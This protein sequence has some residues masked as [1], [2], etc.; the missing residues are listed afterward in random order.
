MLKNTVMQSREIKKA[1][2]TSQLSLLQDDELQKN[3]NKKKPFKNKESACLKFFLYQE[4]SKLKDLLIKKNEARIKNKIFSKIVAQKYFVLNFLIDATIYS[5][6]DYFILP[7]QISYVKRLTTLP[8][9]LTLQGNK[10]ARAFL[11]TYINDH[12]FVEESTY[13]TYKNIIIEELPSAKK[14]I[15]TETYTKFVSENKRLQEEYLVQFFKNKTKKD[16][17]DLDFTSLKDILC[18]LNINVFKKANTSN[19][20]LAIF[21]FFKNPEKY[22]TA[23]P[24]IYFDSTSN[25][26]QMIATTFHNKQAAIHSC[27]VGEEKY[28]INKIFLKDINIFF[29]KIKILSNDIISKSGYDKALLNKD[30]FCQDINHIHNLKNIF[31]INDLICLLEVLSQKEKHM[32]TSCFTYGVKRTYIFDSKTLAFDLIRLNFIIEFIMK[33]ESWLI[34]ILQERD[35]IKKRIMAEAYGMTQSGGMNAIENAINEYAIEHGHIS[36]NIPLIRLFANI[37]NKYFWAVFK[38]IYL[39]YMID[40]LTLNTHFKNLKRP[41]KYSDCYGEWHYIP[42][43]SKRLQCSIK[44]Y[45]KSDVTRKSKYNR[46]HI[47]VK[48]YSSNLDNK[49]IQSSYCPFMI[50]SIETMLTNT[51]L[52]TGQSLNKSLLNKLN[53][54]YS[55]VPNFDCFATNIDNAT[56]ILHH[57]INSYNFVYHQSPID[58]IRNT[59]NELSSDTCDTNENVNIFNA[60]KALNLLQQNTNSSNYWDGIIRNPYFVKN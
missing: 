5:H 38:P 16:L 57:L 6:F 42:R 20:A 17:L 21:H 19:M 59:F 34:N 26:T 14:H 35:L 22:T 41:L 56:L 51:Y 31:D 12:K 54:T 9:F 60:N 40:F 49:K 55:V 58:N 50:H 27:L 46:R 33:E 10:F 28:D 47:N 11:M 7:R 15:E 18:N 48:L 2:E 30:L 39:T 8:T 3:S 1:Q 43:K 23:R 52:I 53:I 45:Y 13:E 24:F 37:I 4:D 29:N 25:G 36:Y 44:E 32:I